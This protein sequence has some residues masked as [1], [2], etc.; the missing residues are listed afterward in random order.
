MLNSSGGSSSVEITR[1]IS[2]G[3]LET[4]TLGRSGKN[5]P[6]GSRTPQNKRRK[7]RWQDPATGHALTAGGILFYDDLGVW[8]IGEKDKN[9]IV[10]TDIGGRY[11]YEDGNIWTTIRRELYEE[12][13]G[14]CEMF[15]SDI[16]TFSQ[17]YGNIY[18]N[19]HNNVP[20]YVCLVVPVADLRFDAHFRLDPRTFEDRRITTLRENP[21][22]PVNYYCPC[23]LAKLS[24]E[25]LSDPVFRLSHRLKR[26]LKFSAVLAQ[27]MYQHTPL[28]EVTFFESRD[29]D[30]E[31][32]ED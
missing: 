27:K 10:Y 13:Y 2:A 23:L 25:D 20:T 26:I 12:T 21:D 19:G 32:V 7:F 14:T 15:T 22:V 29:E 3:D 17:R 31:Y 28:P 24:Y 8:V 5:T 9:G 18:V 30:D 1:S 16:V 6:S 11:T 4:P